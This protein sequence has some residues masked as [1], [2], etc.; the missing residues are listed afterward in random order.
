MFESS[1]VYAHHLSKDLAIQTIFCIFMGCLRAIVE[2]L[3]PTRVFGRPFVWV[4][5]RVLYVFF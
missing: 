5:A 1:R 4:C 2:L 3:L